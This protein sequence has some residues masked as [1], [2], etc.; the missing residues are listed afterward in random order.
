MSSAGCSRVAEPTAELVTD[1][2]AVA[3]VAR[4]VLVPFALIAFSAEA[5]AGIIVLR[6]V[7][8]VSR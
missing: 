8:E 3:P 1:D 2:D 7:Y 6:M 4:A 5:L